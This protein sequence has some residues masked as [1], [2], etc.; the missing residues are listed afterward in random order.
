MKDTPLAE[1]V[2]VGA[3][4]F[5]DRTKPDRNNTK[6]LFPTLA[7]ELADALPD[8]KDLLCQAIEDNHNVSD[9]SSR[10]QWRNLI[11]EPL[12][13]LEKRILSLMTLVIVIDAMDEC[14]SEN[15]VNLIFHL[16]SEVKDLE[17][18]IRIF[19]TS[20][21]EQHI[22]P[23]FRQSLET[24]ATVATLKKVSTASPSSGQKDDILLFLEDSFREI[25]T[26]YHVAPDWPGAE[27]IRQLSR[28]ADGLFMYAAT[29][30]RFIGDA[31]FEE[32][33]ETRLELVFQNKVSGNSPQKG[34]DAIYSQ[35]VGFS[36]L[37]D[38]LD[39][40]RDDISKRFSLV[41][42]SIVVLYA[43]LPVCV[44]S[45][46]LKLD[47]AR[48]SQILGRLSSVLSVP[49]EGHTPIELLHLSFRDFLVSQDRC[50]DPVFLIDPLVAHG[51]LIDRCLQT[52]SVMLPRYLCA[53][54]QPEFEIS[55]LSPDPVK[56]RI[57]PHLRYACLKWGFH[58]RQAVMSPARYDDVQKFLETH[59]LHWLEAL[60]IMEYIPD[61]VG[62]IVDLCDHLS[63]PSV[64]TS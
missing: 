64:S 5:F 50:Q 54:G 4:F 42:G 25:R 58:L 51:G 1:N 23:G 60:S 45:E 48:V 7:R 36:I 13:R 26:R 17:I 44:P 19:M 63:L 21:R 46:L 41:V 10:D 47:V 20:R 3:S 29:A 62:M 11:L 14:S 37:G 27:K 31:R 52:M 33:L 28:Q 43:P 57:P 24:I 6:R 35:I 32:Y 30:C 56:Q 40:E 55:D 18:R 49:E 16:L 2:C 38:V 9:Q 22:R 53:Q 34:L 8:F 12:S 61:G 39:E 15:D 59:F